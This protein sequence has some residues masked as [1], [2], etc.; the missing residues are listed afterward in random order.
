M[1][2]L[3]ELARYLEKRRVPP[4]DW[5]VEHA[6][7][8]TLEPM[9]H[10][11]DATASGMLGTLA[12]LW[13]PGDARLIEAIAAVC[14]A[15]A[16]K[17]SR[18]YAV[19]FVREF[20]RAVVGERRTIYDAVQRLKAIDDSTL[21]THN[22]LGTAVELVWTTASPKPYY[23]TPLSHVRCFDDTIDRAYIELAMQSTPAWRDRRS[24]RAIREV[25]AAPSLTEVLARV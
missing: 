17:R 18:Q 22:V 2:P 16:R 5:I 3:I 6:A 12:M 9:W 8:G 1:S 23:P 13:R 11:P 10:G 24:V 21:Y 4:F 19:A 14:R 20:R 7:D 25:V 15:W